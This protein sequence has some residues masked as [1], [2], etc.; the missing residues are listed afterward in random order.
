MLQFRCTIS[1][2]ISLNW[3][4]PICLPHGASK[5][6]KSRNLSTTQA[7]TIGMD[8]FELLM[9]CCVQCSPAVG[10]Q[11]FSWIQR[12][13]TDVMTHAL[14]RSHCLLE[15]SL[16]FL[17]VQ[18]LVRKQLEW[19]KEVRS[20]A[21]DANVRMLTNLGHNSCLNQHMSKQL[22]SVMMRLCTV[23][24][25]C[26]KLTVMSWV[27]PC[28][29]RGGMQMLSSLKVGK[30]GLSQ[31]SSH[32]QPIM[33]ASMALLWLLKRSKKLEM[34]CSQWQCLPVSIK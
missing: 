22:A 25:M 28:P 26:L 34:P 2:S 19:Q 30:D 10:M 20:T 31:Q 24:R 3:E 1:G 15:N 7:L 16:M 33:S 6:G 17:H 8:S 32:H 13:P 4:V 18:T 11:G 12:R 5:H 9:P 21:F 29:K 27:Q 14:S 23:W